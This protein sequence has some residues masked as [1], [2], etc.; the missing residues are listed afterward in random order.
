MGCSQIQLLVPFPA[1]TDNIHEED[2][3][4]ETPV[5]SVSLPHGITGLQ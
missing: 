4:A 5:H 2:T 3:L 1:I